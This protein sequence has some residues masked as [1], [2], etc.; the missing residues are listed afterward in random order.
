MLVVDLDARM[1]WA[2]VMNRGST[3]AHFLD[4]RN[5]ALAKALYAVL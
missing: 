3:G 4:P 1:S 5:R 2:Y